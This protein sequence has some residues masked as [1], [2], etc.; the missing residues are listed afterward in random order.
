MRRWTVGLPAAVTD[1]SVTERDYPFC[2]A[3]LQRLDMQAPDAIASG[4]MVHAP[5]TDCINAGC[6]HDATFSRSCFALYAA[7]RLNSP[8]FVCTS[9]ASE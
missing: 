1:K 3:M 5:V 8:R 6:D 9:H 7:E 2:V 4:A